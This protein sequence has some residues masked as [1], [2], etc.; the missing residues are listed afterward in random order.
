MIIGQLLGTTTTTTT[1]TRA[2]FHVESRPGKEKFFN[3]TYTHHT[4]GNQIIPEAGVS[5]DCGDVEV[6]M[7]AILVAGAE[8]GNVPA[9]KSE[10]SIY[11]VIIYETAQSGKQ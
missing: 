1:T 11:I 7:E 10:F 9:E 3:A 2:D 6:E 4:N 5:I 8:K